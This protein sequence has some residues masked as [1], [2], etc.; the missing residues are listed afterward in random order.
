MDPNTPLADPDA[1]SIFFAGT[2]TT[3]IRFG[4]FTVLTDPNFLHRGEV[5]RLGYGL[6]S[7]R[8]TEPALQPEGLPPLDVLVLSHLHEDHF[9]RVAEARLPR[10]VPIVTTPSDMKLE[11]HTAK[12]I[13]KNGNSWLTAINGTIEEIKEYY[14]NRPWNVSTVEDETAGITIYS[15]CVAVEILS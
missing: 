11:R 14:L 1:G 12:V 2:A 3:V 13:L 10:S 5:V 7:R 15:K 8:R 6:R 9:D 4:G